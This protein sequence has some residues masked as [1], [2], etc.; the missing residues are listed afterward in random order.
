MCLPAGGENGRPLH[1]LR[2]PEVMAQ[3]PGSEEAPQNDDQILTSHAL[4][5]VSL[6]NSSTIESEME[7]DM[8]RGVL[9]SY[10]IPSVVSVT[11]YAGILGVEVKVPRGRL[12]EAERLIEEARAAGPAAAE[13]AEAA[14]EE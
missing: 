6:Y 3:D 11:P 9:D 12:K 1:I 14:S 7:A 5:L 4:D 8:I 10:G 13:E 2:Y